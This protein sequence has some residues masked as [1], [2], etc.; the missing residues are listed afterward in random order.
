MYSRF[1]AERFSAA[2]RC[3]DVFDCARRQWNEI[4][5]IIVGAGAVR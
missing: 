4:Q 3:A 5:A 2:V 1:S